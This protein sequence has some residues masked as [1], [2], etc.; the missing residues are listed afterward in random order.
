MGMI[1][2]QLQQQ[3]G[4]VRTE[5]VVDKKKKRRSNRRSKHNSSVLG[6]VSTELQHAS[7]SFQNGS[8]S[9]SASSSDQHQLE[10]YEASSLAFNSLPTM[11]FDQPVPN[12]DSATQLI[13]SSC[14]TP[15]TFHHSSP[16]HDD[17]DFV[18]PY[19]LYG[20]NNQKFFDPHWPLDVVTEA[21]QRGEV[22]QAILR[23]NAHNRLEAYCTIEGVPTDV[24]IG[25]IPRQNRAVEG[26]VVAVKVDP[27]P[28]WSK[29]KGSSGSGN[30][31]S[32]T[33]NHEPSSV[34]SEINQVSFKGKSLLDVE[35]GFRAVTNCSPVE[36]NGCGSNYINVNGHCRSGLEFSGEGCPLEENEV[37]NS[38]EKLYHV[39][40]SNPYKRPTG[41]VVAIIE[42]S[43]RRDAV[44]GVL[45]A[46]WLLHSKE[47]FRKENRKSKNLLTPSNCDYIQFIPTD[48]KLPKMIVPVGALS[49]DIKKRLDDADASIERD[50]VAA[51]IDNWPEESLLPQACVLGS[52][53]H[54]GEIESR[55]EAVLFENAICSS[56]FTVESLSCLPLESWQVPQAELQRRKDIRNLCVFTIDPSTATDLDDAL[57]VE[58]LSNGNYRVGVHIADVSYFVQPDT[59]LDV[60]A[61]IRSTS[62]YM[63]RRK[64]PML[65]ALLSENLG[66]LIPGVDRLTFSI[67][68]DLNVS[69][70]ILDR[71]VGRTVIRSCC[72][73]SYDHAQDII[74]GRISVDSLETDGNDFPHLYGRFTWSDVFQSVENLNKISKALKDNRFVNGALRLDNAK[75]VFVLDE[76]GLPYDGILSQRKDSNFL[77]EEFMLLANRTAAEI[78]TRAFPDS[79][80]LRRHPEPNMRK[81]REFEVFCSKHGL[82]LD[83]SSSGSLHRSLEKIKEKLKD[84][85]VFYDI[86]INYA[87]KPMQLAKYFCTGDETVPQDGWGHYA[88]AAPLYTHFT[89]PLRRYPDIVVHRT[90]SAV[91]E[92]EQMFF[93]HQSIGNK[94]SQ[95][96]N[97][98]CFTGMNFDKLAFQSFIGQQVLSAAALKHRLPCKETLTHVASYCNQKKL[99]SR[100]VK[101]A[102]DKLYMW[103]LLRNKEILL[104]EARVLGIGPR[105]MSIYV[106]KL[107]IERRI[108]YDDVDGLVAEW[109]EATSTLVLNYVYSSKRFQRKG[110]PG[111][112]KLLEEVALIC[113]PCNLQPDFDALQNDNSGKPCKPTDCLKN[114]SQSAMKIDPAVFPLT[115]RVLSTIP[116][117]LHAVGGDDGPVDIAARLYVT[118]YFR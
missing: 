93:K 62:V 59:P 24:F 85:L 5:D 29:M 106:Q 98:R 42:P 41:R 108:Y 10:Q 86:V 73:L 116:V 109:L 97:D 44:V 33:D 7:H 38:V 3:S 14:P 57:S 53:G 66:S 92:A 91:I 25:G 22:F 46:N 9:T 94:L 21:L 23:V 35:S 70:E 79:A 72:K 115:I 37:L 40:V 49:A 96:G 90:L 110:S 88:L 75:V 13:S 105:F 103:V 17:G 81:L 6:S 102:V 8:M 65:P 64:L 89:S 16:L 113:S 36:E 54:G 19:L 15:N 83:V 27:L 30:N 45:N 95:A 20:S 48:P 18:P 114:S 101:D 77:V 56:D 55:I 87:T 52:F 76:C 100:H 99:A 69:G 61:Q 71:W 84:D 39:V 2:E 104:S 32:P 118:S 11:N 117:A 1:V 63:L 28:L 4:G 107:A 50:L 60:E 58:R 34:D 82:E 80:L 43:L 111:K 67:F 26:D 12:I 31:L 112:H 68:W 74:D 51:R 47:G 78:I